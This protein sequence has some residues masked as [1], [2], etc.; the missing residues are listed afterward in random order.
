MLRPVPA[1]TIRKNTHLGHDEPPP[2]FKSVDLYVSSRGL[3][4]DFVEM[5]FPHSFGI[6]PDRLIVVQR[7]GGMDTT[8]PTDVTPAAW[9]DG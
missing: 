1:H 3:K 2:G 9:T 5:Q 4:W 6:C 8:C 7:S